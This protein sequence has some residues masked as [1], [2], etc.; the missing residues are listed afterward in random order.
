MQ[1]KNMIG[2]KTLMHKLLV[3]LGTRPEVIKLKPVIEHLRNQ[4]IINLIVRSYIQI[5]IKKWAPNYL[6]FLK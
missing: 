1:S 5:N 2:K 4:I 6:I 3:I